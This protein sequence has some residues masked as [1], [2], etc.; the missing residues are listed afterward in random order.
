MASPVNFTGEFTEKPWLMLIPP[1]DSR[2]ASYSI[3]VA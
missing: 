2:T 3:T 1:G